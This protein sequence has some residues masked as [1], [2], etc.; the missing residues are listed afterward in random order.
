M[1]LYDRDYTQQ[2]YQP[3]YGYRTSSPFQ[4]HAPRTMVGRLLLINI[5][6]FI[7]QL[8][9]NDLSITMGPNGPIFGTITT[10]FAVFPKNIPF[11]L[12]PWRL[13]TYQFL[14]G[15]FFHILFNMY[16]LY[17]FGRLI[18]QTLG[19]KRFLIFYLICGIA[20]GI[21]YPILT[22]VNWLPIGPMVGASG[23]ILGII[24]AVAVLYPRMKV[25]VFPIFIP[26]SIRII[27]FGFAI[28]F[29]LKVIFRSSNAGGEAAHL[30]GMV[31]GVAY[32]MWP[33][34]KGK[35]KRST[36]GQKW[37]RQRQSEKE[38]LTQLDD[39]LE[40][41]H[42]KGIHSLSRKDKQILRKATKLQQH[43]K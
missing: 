19:P 16:V 17:M 25:I 33:A 8:L 10:W 22:L 38:L 37:Q 15:D 28:L 21:L 11:I 39:I 18:E 40:K 1:G 12:Q 36:A 35:F 29:A 42:D 31:T 20:G 41:V 43:K 2:D 24:G 5:S 34:M 27:A 3:S 7:L 32:I 9:T 4:F 13:I 6:V 26:I 23:A 14:H 30:A